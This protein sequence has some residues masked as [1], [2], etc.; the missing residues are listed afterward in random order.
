MKPNKDTCEWY[1]PNCQGVKCRLIC[2][3]H[4]PKV[5]R[6][7]ASLQKRKSRSARIKARIA[8]ALL[9]YNARADEAYN[10]QKRREESGYGKKG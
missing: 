3:E 7:I 8:G 5:E 1:G 4:I 2:Y 9:A 6:R 10:T